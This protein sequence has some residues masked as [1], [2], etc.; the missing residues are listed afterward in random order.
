[1]K[2][3]ALMSFRAGSKQ[4]ACVEAKEGGRRSLSSA[5]TMLAVLS[6]DG[7][8]QHMTLDEHRVPL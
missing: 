6:H 3:Q 7:R 8:R 4:G 1:V 2:V 5:L